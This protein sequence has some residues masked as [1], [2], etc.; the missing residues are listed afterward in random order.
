[1]SARDVLQLDTLAGEVCETQPARETLALVN[2][3]NI[4]AVNIALALNAA[5]VGS[6]AMAFAGQSIYGIHY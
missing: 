5:S 3:T 2:I 1:M 4:T 6:Q